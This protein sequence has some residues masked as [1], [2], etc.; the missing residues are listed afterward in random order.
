LIRLSLL[1]EEEVLA[2][3]K[4]SLAQS[5]QIVTEKINMGWEVDKRNS[6]SY[7]GRFAFDVLLHDYWDNLAVAPS[8][9]QC[10]IE[11]KEDQPMLHLNNPRW[12]LWFGHTCFFPDYSVYGIQINLFLTRA[13]LKETIVLDRDHERIMDPYTLNG[14]KDG[15]PIINGI[16][17]DYV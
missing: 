7:I 11:W 16:A 10:A 15:P 1:T 17:D 13:A 12:S 2:S 4:Q 3:H 9:G 8:R 14:C 5:N 6:S